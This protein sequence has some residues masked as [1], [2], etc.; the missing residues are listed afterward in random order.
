MDAVIPS[1][2]FHV[3]HSTKNNTHHHG[4]PIEAGTC[5][6]KAALQSVISLDGTTHTPDT[7]ISA[8]AD[9][10]IYQRIALQPQEVVLPW[11]PTVKPKSVGRACQTYSLGLLN[12]VYKNLLLVGYCSRSDLMVYTVQSYRVP[13]LFCVCFSIGKKIA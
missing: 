7:K 3:V 6:I 13:I 1:K 2:Y 4:W 5:L 12:L 11:D 8:Q 10:T 9:M